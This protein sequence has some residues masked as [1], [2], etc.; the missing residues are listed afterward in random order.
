MTKGISESR[1][2]VPGP[3][4]LVPSLLHIYWTLHAIH[5][6]L[7][8]SAL[9]AWWRSTPAPRPQY[10]VLWS[11]A[12][13]ACLALLFWI[14]G[15]YLEWPSDPWEHLRRINEW[16]ILD[17]VTTHSSWKKSSYFLPYSLTQHVTGLTQLSWLNLY[18]TVM[19]L[20]L[21]WQYY[22]LARAVGLGAR[23]SLVF[24]LL[25][26]LTFGNN[27]FSFYRYYGLSSS[28][29]AQLGAVALTR[30]ALE[31]VRP[32]V[33]KARVFWPEHS[34]RWLANSGLCKS[35]SMVCGLVVCGPA[36]IAL[37]A[38]TA[39]NHIQG[40][41]IAGLGILAVIV[42][43]LIEWKR[44]MI[45][46][47]VLAAVLASVAT[48]LWFPRHPAFD[49]VYRQQGW[50]TTWYGFNFFSSAS[51]AFERSL[52]ILGVF[53]VLNLALGLWLIMRRNHV[54]GWLTLMP[55]IALVLPCF[56][57]PFAHA[58]ATLSRP[59]SIVTFHRFLFA[60]PMGLA[61][62]ATASRETRS[63]ARCVARETGNQ[64]L[65]MGTDPTPTA[66][67]LPF[68]K[69][70]SR[71]NGFLPLGVAGLASAVL[72]SP[73]AW[74]F[75]RLWHSLQI[76]PDDLNLRHYIIAWTPENLA[77][78]V[79]DS[80]LTIAHP[81]TLKVREAFLPGQARGRLR[82]L[83]TALATRD[84]ELQLNWLGSI[85]PADWLIT[86]TDCNETW[87]IFSRICSPKE[88][89]PLH[90]NI[91]ASD[92]PWLRLGGRDPELEYVDERLMIR[93][94]PGASTQA[95]S[96]LLFPVD[97]GK[98]YRLTSSVRQ[99]G[100][101]SAVNYLAVAWYGKDGRLLRSTLNPPEGAGAP[102][103][104]SN[105]TYS[106]Y[107]LSGR[108]APEKWTSYS[109][110]FGLGQAAAIP[111]NAA[112]LRTGGLLNFR[113]VRD[114]V[115]SLSDIILNEESPYDTLL[116]IDPAPRQMH[117]PFSSAARHSR[118]WL[119]Q[120]ANIDQGGSENL[121]SALPRPLH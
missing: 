85:T 20:L 103:G 59:E 14:P 60:V 61:L 101:P 69:T 86:R 119:P 92:S 115:V 26:A 54:A 34:G 19:C 49:E 75:N 58:L 3:W 42:W 4:S 37:A 33:G 84:V 45:G 30:L 121:R 94:P 8:V 97:R 11:L 6:I 96:S 22:R 56:A 95:F 83:H 38:L 81:L 77:G 25:S 117:S 50:L 106:Y 28:I 72:L 2:V 31:A 89:P 41:G 53:G 57:L 74:P 108:P 65:A 43:R 55:I 64:D 114:S 39:F 32:Q 62:M 44:V 112:F 24:V 21:S 82:T 51:P 15:L 80:T 13:W 1:S 102:P 78:A 99:T 88:P 12:P 67:F 46:W 47:L 40:I 107:G 105:G 120:S 116:L 36:V 63:G 110:T 113:S 23:A 91:T 10:S 71:P 98:R 93:N 68:F 73:S 5:L 18:Y 7:G 76:T 118:H 9:R 90:V 79:D 48:V 17:Q 35:W 109:I 29:F 52:H 70:L 111:A 16:H 66:Y 100:N 87:R 27:I 104:W